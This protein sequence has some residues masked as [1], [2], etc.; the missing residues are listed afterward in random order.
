MSLLRE[1]I[2]GSAPSTAVFRVIV[3]PVTQ[4]RTHN[5]PKGGGGGGMDKNEKQRD[6]KVKEGTSW[7]VYKY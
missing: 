2:V 3:F 5:T 4:T 1:T 7:G 6:V